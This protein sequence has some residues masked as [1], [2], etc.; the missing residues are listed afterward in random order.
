MPHKQLKNITNIHKTQAQSWPFQGRGQRDV[1]L[2]KRPAASWLD[3]LHKAIFLRGRGHI[4]GWACGQRGYG[5]PNHLGR[6]GHSPQ[7]CLSLSMWK[8][9]LSA[10]PS[11]KPMYFIMVSLRSS[12]RALPSISCRSTRSFAHLQR[13]GTHGL[14]WGFNNVHAF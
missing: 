4:G 2:V 13:D 5:E 8:V 6:Q 3:Q 12:S 1:A 9:S 11:F 14:S 10:G 7:A